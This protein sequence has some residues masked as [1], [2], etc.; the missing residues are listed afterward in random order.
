MKRSSR[1]ALLT[2]FLSRYPMKQFTLNTFSNMVNS[3]KTS[4]YEDID[5]IREA[6]EENNLGTIES[7]LGASGGVRY[8]P[9]LS[10]EVLYN[11]LIEI[12][13]KLSDP[14]R[15]VLDEYIYCSD[16]LSNPDHL[17]VIAAFFLRHIEQKV[18]AVL[19]VETRGICLAYALAELLNVNV[20]VA[21]KQNSISEGNS[22]S[23]H[24]KSKS[25]KALKTMYVSKLNH[26][27]FKNV[28]IVDA[29]SRAGGTILGLKMLANELGASV[30]KSFV[31]MREK[32]DIVDDIIGVYELKK[33]L[34]IEFQSYINELMRG[35][36]C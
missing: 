20:V 33:S 12:K 18:D 21:R 10:E 15:R 30:H 14:R 16:I 7:S 25:S 28:V 9:S 13:D 11:S 29:F 26:S 22:I 5:I 6:I 27:V 24:Y 35:K 8:V 36:K 1:I 23:V 17:K 19:T 31:F 4:I 3:A 2:N 34:E 32:S